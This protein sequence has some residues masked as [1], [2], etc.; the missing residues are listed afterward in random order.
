MVGIQ[1]DIPTI[2]AA[3]RP[4]TVGLWRQA[5]LSIDSLLHRQAGFEPSHAGGAGSAAG[6]WQAAGS[7]QGGGGG[8]QA[9]GGADGLGAGQR[10]P[11]GGTDE[12]RASSTHCVACAARCLSRRPPPVPTARRC[13]SGPCLMSLA[14]IADTGNK[15][16]NLRK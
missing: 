2:N 13:L 11:G 4:V 8:G 14:V 16:G 5:C 10:A 6:G 9:A 3:C 12:R 1:L 7:G 15:F